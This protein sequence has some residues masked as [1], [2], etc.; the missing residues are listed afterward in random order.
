M[1]GAMVEQMIAYM[2]RLDCHPEYLLPAIVLVGIAMGFNPPLPVAGLLIAIAAVISCLCPSVG[3]AGVL[4]ATPFI[5]RPVEID[6]WI[7][8]HLELALIAL[9]AGFAGR[10][11]IDS[12]HDRSLQTPVGLLKPWG[13]VIGAIALVGLGAISIVTLADTEHRDASIR[14]LRTVIL[15]PL[16]MIPVARSALR[17]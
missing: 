15:E 3:L 12:I 5:F 9:A 6:G 1:D 17:K 4:A 13:P 10:L 2:R 16:V 14:A 8:T 7:F 11:A